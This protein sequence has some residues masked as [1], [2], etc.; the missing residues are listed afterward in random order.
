MAQYFVLRNC[1]TGDR[2]YAQ[3]NVVDLPPDL[4]KS[5]KNFRAV[6][7]AVSPITPAEPVMP[8]LAL[9]G[10]GKDAMGAT[11]PPL[12]WENAEVYV[13]DKKPTTKST[14]KKN[15]KK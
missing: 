8:V 3:G 14:T 12:D 4:E 7:E 15:K 9:P 6:D 11:D 2:Y 13:S 5:P 10:P 1:F